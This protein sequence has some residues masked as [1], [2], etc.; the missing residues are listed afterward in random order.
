MSQT[1]IPK[2]E[3]AQKFTICFFKRTALLMLLIGIIV[4][5][6]D[7]FYQY[8]KP[9]FGLK[10]VLTDKEYQ[11][12]GSLRTFDYD[13]LIVGSSVAENYYNAWFNDGFHCTTIKAIRSY[14]A[15]ADLCYLLDAA[16]KEHQLKYV[17]YNMDTSSLSADPVPSYEITGCP[18]YLYNDNYLDDVEYLFNK[19]VLFE[20]IPHMAAQSIIGDYDENNSYNWAQWKQF[21]ESQTL[22]LY[23]RTREIA[24]MKEKNFYREN[25]EANLQLISTLV[26][27]HPET[28]Y[29]I[30]FPPYSMLWWDNIYRTGDLE[31]YIYNMEQAIGQLLTYENVEIYY[32][33]NEKEMITNLN[34]YMDTLHFTQDINQYMCEQIISGRNQLTLDNYKQTLSEMK[35]FA[36]EIVQKLIV[37]YE[38]RIG[39]G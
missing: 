24:P 1:S 14:G 8:H 10:A 27:E 13:S 37:P 2:K 17:F 33:Q 32:F 26:Q 34:N 16:Y 7:P 6:I 21:T 30:F 29:K 19:G 20:K 28:K 18:M 39:V 9:W 5:L 3:T 15:T 31:A 22:R 23:D 36:Y 12:I 35:K 4:V 11:C 25:L 38:D